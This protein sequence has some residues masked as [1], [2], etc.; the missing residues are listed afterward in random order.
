MKLRT[1]FFILT[2][3]IF[4][5]FMATAWLYSRYLVT[6]INEQ[7]ALRLTEKQ[8]Q[9]DKH[10]TLQ[11]L[12]REIA[13]ARRLA[14]E[15]ALIDMA[16]HEEDEAV[17]QR[18]L[19]VIEQ[20]RLQFS[21]HN[22]FLAMAKSG[23]YYFNDAS[24]QYANQQLRYTLARGNSNDEWFFATAASK[25]EYQ[26]NVD[27]D[28]HLGGIKVWINVQVKN[29]DEVV[30]VIGTGIDIGEFIQDT[31]GV[32]Q[33]D[34]HN[35]FVDRDMAVQ[36]HADK[37][38]IDYA[39]LT[40]SV[41]QRR[42]VDVLIHDPGDLA[43]LR[44]AMRQLEAAPELTKTLW[45]NYAGKKML[46]GVAYLPE[47]GW[48]DLTLVE[49]GG[50]HLLNPSSFVLVFSILILLAF[51]TMA[52][53]FH[54][55]V[56][57]PLHTIG[58]S[59]RQIQKGHFETDIPVVGT[60][61]IF[62]LSTQFKN[63]VEIIRSHHHDL[64]SKIVQRTEQLWR[65]LEERKKTELNLRENDERLRL[66]MTAANQGWF[67]V[68]LSNG[69]VFLSPEYLK[70]LGYNPEDSQTNLDEWRNNLHPDDKEYTLKGFNE[71]VA[72]GGPT[73][74]QYRRR[75]ANGDWLWV[76]SV[77]KITEWDEQHK[78]LKMVGIHTDISEHK[79]IL[80]QL[81]NTATELS[82]ANIQI[83][84]E[85]AQLAKRVAERTTQLQYAN[86]AKDSFLAT[87]SHEIRTPLG[88][89]LGMMELLSL[90]QLSKEQNEI[91]DAAQKSGKSLLRIVND[92]LD[93]S[94]IEAGKL[95]LAPRV[96]T[97][98]DML[99]SVASTYAQIASE[100]DLQLNIV[101]D[102]ELSAA[103]RFDPLRVSQILNNF[104]S[105]AIKFTEQGYIK[106]S[107][108][109]VARR[110][111][112]EIVR[113]SVQDSGVGISIEAQKRLFKQYEQASAETARMYGGTGLGLAICRRLA[114]LMGGDLSVESSP[115]VG[116]TFSFMVGLA[117][118]QPAALAPQESEQSSSTP[119]IHALFGAEKE[120]RILVVDDHPLNRMLLKQQLGLLGL[121]AEQATDGV[122]A[123]AKYQAAHF[124]LIITDCHMPEMDGYELTYRI[125]DMEHQTGQARVPIIAWTANVLAEEAEHC[126]VAGMDD[127]LTK[128]TELSDLRAT[129]AK[130]LPH[131]NRQT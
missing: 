51:L 28:A 25:L 36:L 64:E 55:L 3:V 111:D 117:I 77:G 57:L 78:P 76:S 61:E 127:L 120:V 89:L 40:K 123:L 32:A 50:L 69:K 107:A 18:A 41:E 48:F 34:M 54:R 96:A 49:G 21:D 81:R 116:S 29:G 43:Q 115:G 83:E 12:L 65:E 22:Y 10:R 92:I 47:I 35:L 88:G 97:L 13:L 101:I 7:W 71:C 108:T 5:A 84:E 66:A 53:A 19:A 52:V 119:N 131:A 27:P 56:L 104:T 128:P 80:E 106:V 17:R 62:Q 60:A 59:I 87:M 30:A 73:T 44:V 2:G 8:V 79:E 122:D 113:F 99:K 31:V 109:R 105:N 33:N 112:Q 94:K 118:A 82:K 23:H 6:K 1:R 125:R 63:M 67:Y 85:R 75:K 58:L 126:H 114:E 11:P 16:T 42:K 37:S 103:H 24:N 70:I 100:K 91:L 130:W 98:S 93:W 38:L 102:P 124:D 74:L 4:L 90:S 86:H 72:T 46:L 14:I 110:D 45:V 129:L 121:Q 26:V 68:D 20:Y 95:E 39:S 15:P 9:F